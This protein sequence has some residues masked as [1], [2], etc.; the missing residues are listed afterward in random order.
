MNTETE[1]A[2]D[3]LAETP[4]QGRKRLKVVA[5]F[6]V[7]VLAAFALTSCI[8][9]EQNKV[10]SLMNNDRANN[11]RPALTDW[12]TADLRSQ[13]WAE[14]LAQRW[15]SGH[16]RDVL[17][18]SNL[19]STY[20]SVPVTEKYCLAENIGYASGSTSDTTKI[21]AIQKAYMKSPGHRANILNRHYTRTGSG[22]AKA[23][24]GTLFTVQQF[25][26]HGT[27]ADCQK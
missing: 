6:A 27:W 5:A 21:T 8:T 10:Q 3:T 12:F 4:K 20:A 15:D 19:R 16:R 24:D 13:A 17:V 14:H 9:P 7:V 2:D 22:V 25:A 11:G 18:H 26:R 23:Q 1:Q